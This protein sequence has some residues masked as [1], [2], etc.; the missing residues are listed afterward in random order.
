MEWGLDGGV[1]MEMRYRYEGLN[2]RE[3]GEWMGIDYRAVSVMKKRLSAHLE[4]DRSLSG[5]ITKVKERLQSSQ[6]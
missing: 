5:V 3:I 1:L 6:E 2:Q 4:R